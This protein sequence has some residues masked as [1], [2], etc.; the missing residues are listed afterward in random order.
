M[1]SYLLPPTF[2]SSPPFPI[3]PYVC[4]VPPELI[5]VYGTSWTPKIQEPLFQLKQKNVYEQ[6]VPRNFPANT[7]AHRHSLIHSKP[8]LNHHIRVTPHPIPL[9]LDP[10]QKIS[11]PHIYINDSVTHNVSQPN[12]GQATPSTWPLLIPYPKGRG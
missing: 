9:P 5:T 1:F 7:G 11:K 8:I 2:P 10:L 12:V 4:S 3:H 6:K